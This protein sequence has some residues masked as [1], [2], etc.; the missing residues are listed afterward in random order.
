MKKGGNPEARV[1][2]YLADGFIEKSFLYRERT[3]FISV[4]APFTYRW[5]P[6]T[7]TLQ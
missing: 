4:Y 1:F 3:Y 6:F 2:I 7:M 5:L